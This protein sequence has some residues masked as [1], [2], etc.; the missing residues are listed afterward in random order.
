LA[1]HHPKGYLKVKQGHKARP[2]WNMAQIKDNEAKPEAQPKKASTSAVFTQGSIP[3]HIRLMATPMAWGILAMVAA[4]LVDAFFLG[5]LGTRYLAAI[6]FTF[7]V[8]ALL[9]NLTL[10]LGSG[11]A[12]VLARAIGQ[13]R[14]DYA[15]HLTLSAMILSVALVA[16]LSLIGLFTINPLFRALGA[17][18]ETLPLVRDYM[19]IFYLTMVFTVVPM[20]GNFVLR[21][22]GDARTAGFIM[23]SSALL[24]MLLDPILIFGLFGLPRLEIQGAALASA[25]ARAASLC[26]TF[27]ILAVRK[28]LLVLRVPRRHELLTSWAAILKVGAPLAGANMVAPISMFVITALL[29]RYGTEVVAGFGIAMR[30]EGL[31]TIPL[32]AMASGLSPIVGQNYAAAL[33]D[34]V[35]LTIQSASK[36]ALFY[37]LSCAVI[38]GALHRVLP[39]FFDSNPEVIHSAGLYL[40][41]VP[42]GFAAIGVSMS[43]GASYNGMGNPKPSVSFTI[44]R[45]VVI[46]L[47]FAFLGSYLLGPLG[48]Y[49]AGTLANILVGVGGWIWV[50]RQR[51]TWEASRTG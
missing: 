1:S 12:S 35:V 13:G 44:S 8:I 17:G 36:F 40:L 34:R 23:I 45:M 15:E 26:I 16:I 18:P 33:I 21:A 5:Q 42:L 25:I 20:T 27:Y 24:A 3:R 4:S 39:R 38:L 30:I 22:T 41:S 32:M 19:F 46:Y 11:V 51:R 49:M 9:S 29:A 10:G 2:G 43:I 28:N 48:I 47:P 37:G 50:N 14:T 7:P 6:T 31:A